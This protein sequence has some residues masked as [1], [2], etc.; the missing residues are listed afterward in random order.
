ME[1]CVRQWDLVGFRDR[2]CGFGSVSDLRFS[3]S[4]MVGVLVR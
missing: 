2:L 1:S 4:A 3:L